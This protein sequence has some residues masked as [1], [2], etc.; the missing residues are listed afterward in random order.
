MRLRLKMINRCRS[1]AFSASSR[2]FD[3]N[4]EAD[5][6]PAKRATNS[7]PGYRGLKKRA[8]A[9]PIANAPITKPNEADACRASS[10]CPRLNKTIISNAYMPGIMMTIGATVIVIRGTSKRRSATTATSSTARASK[11]RCWRKHHAHVD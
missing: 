10:I 7:V 9:K 8:V 5:G 2:N 3:L 4:G 6:S 1:T 11:I